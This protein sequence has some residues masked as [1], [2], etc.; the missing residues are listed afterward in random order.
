MLGTE[1]IIIINYI[2]CGM[3]TFKD[4]DLQKRI[5]EKYNS[6]ASDINFILFNDLEENI[7]DEIKKR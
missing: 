2:E 1:K 5:S 4:Q 3:A 6:N 7:K